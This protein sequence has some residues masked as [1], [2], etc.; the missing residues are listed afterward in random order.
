[1]V[2]KEVQTMKEF[3]LKMAG[4]IGFGVVVDALVEVSR[5]PV[6]NDKGLFGNDTMSNYEFMI[7]GITLGGLTASIVDIATNSK[8]F[9]F[10]KDL[11]PVL[12]GVMIGTQQYESWIADKIGIRKFDPYNFVRGYIPNINSMLPA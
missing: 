1:M 11:V 12:A 6:L 9:G 8:P 5:L 2:N 7:Y 10:S 4:G 3:L